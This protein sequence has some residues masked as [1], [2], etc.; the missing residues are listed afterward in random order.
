MD[1]IPDT[2]QIGHR[3]WLK[4]L[5]FFIFAGGL[6]AFFALGGDQYLTLET[7]KSHR[8]DMLTYVQQHRLLM[9]TGAII[10]YTV[11][12]ALSI[13]GALILSLTVGFLFGRWIGTAIIVI[14]ATF[15]A[16][17]V[18]L[19]ARYL[20]AD[21]A[22]RRVGNVARKIITGFHANAFNYLLFLRL[23]PVFPFWLVNLVPAFTPIHLRTY[24]AATA[25]GII[26]GSF[27]FANLGQ[28]LGRIDSAD[29]IL[30]PQILMAF[31]LLGL[32]ALIP[33]AV[34]KYKLT[35]SLKKS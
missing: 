13:P 28:S 1:S 22:Q 20:F 21:A 30:S 14:S 25:I 19:A 34:K 5:I 3:N 6:I 12:T 35:K 8:D 17:L 23:V 7:V 4:P 33:V 15:G 10:V 9:I 16:T 32:F 29:Q 24:F 26:P 31:V 2:S 27:V 18:F 11:S